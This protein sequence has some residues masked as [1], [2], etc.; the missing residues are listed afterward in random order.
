IRQ[1]A[2]RSRAD[3]NGPLGRRAPF[4]R[5]RT[6]PNSRVNNVTTLL[7][8][9]NSTTRSTRAIAFSVGIGAIV[10]DI[11]SVQCGPEMTIFQSRM[12]NNS[13]ALLVPAA[14]LHRIVILR[15]RT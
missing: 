8:S 10:A 5:P 2:S 11:L 14:A 15:D 1:R 6:L 7:V 12:R 3:S 4:A 13:G 9:L